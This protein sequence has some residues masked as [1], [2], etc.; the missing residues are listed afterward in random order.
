MV[1]LVD[2][3][4]LDEDDEI[5]F[6]LNEKDDIGHGNDE[7]K[8]EN[9]DWKVFKNNKNNNNNNNNNNWFRCDILLC[10]KIENL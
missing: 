7:N 3:E 4:K 5:D 2:I 1:R 6:K 10:N 8:D 9:F